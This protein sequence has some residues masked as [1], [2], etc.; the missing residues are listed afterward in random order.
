MATLVQ[1][2]F[3]VDEAAPGENLQANYDINPQFSFILIVLRLVL[4]ILIHISLLLL[5]IDVESSS[6]SPS[7]RSGQFQR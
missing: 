1:A 5:C 6:H 2:F 7:G 4:N 3:A